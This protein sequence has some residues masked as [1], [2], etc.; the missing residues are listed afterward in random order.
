VPADTEDDNGFDAG[1]LGLVGLTG[2][3]G[4][5]RRDRDEVTRGE[6]NRNDASRGATT[7]V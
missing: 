3:L 4:L 5:K 2:L 1:L 6:V 7:R